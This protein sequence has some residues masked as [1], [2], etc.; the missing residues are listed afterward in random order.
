MRDSFIFYRSF[1]EAV[2]YLDKEAQAD[3]F[4]AI[5]EYV[6]NEKEVELDGAAKALFISIKPQLDANN[7]RYE[8]GCKGGRKKNEP[9]EKAKENQKETKA[10]P[11]ENQKETE[12][13][14]NEN[15]NVNVNAEKEKFNLFFNKYPK[16]VDEYK[17]FTLFDTIINEKIVD[18]DELMKGVERYKEYTARSGT[19]EKFIKSP[20]N[21][22]KDMSWKNDYERKEAKNET[23]YRYN[24]FAN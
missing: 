12:V 22:L 21:W 7:K 10:E 11:K 2:S 4:S 20:Y 23:P 9:E 16:Q 6:L 5:C 14:A 17:T 18:F 15:E 24:A 13:K 1:F 3:C 8:N 19:D